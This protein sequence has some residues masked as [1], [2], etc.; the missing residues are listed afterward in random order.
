VPVFAAV[1]DAP[2]LPPDAGAPAWRECWSLDWHDPATGSA[3]AYRVRA[4]ADGAA[5]VRTWTLAGG[6]VIGRSWTS[7]LDGGPDPGTLRAGGLRLRTLEPLR[8]YA[9]TT[10]P[11]A[12][13][14]QAVDLTYTAAT[15]AFRFSMS[16]QRADPGGEHYESFGTVTGTIRGRTGSRPATAAE[17]VKVD[18]LGFY[19]HSWGV[20]NPGPQLVRSV[21]GMFE[22][23]L[24]F[25]VAEYSTPAG[26][27]PLGYVFE[28]GEFHGVEKAR[29]RAET[30]ES[31]L[32]RS[33]DVLLATADRRDFRIVT[34][35]APATGTGP[36]FAAF[37]LGKYRGSGLFER[38]SLG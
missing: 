33:C 18:G 17:A 28:G 3:A 29:F 9:V 15:D 8:S 16:G 22:A 24:F 30:D 23:G 35:L 32:P 34:A 12:G 11:G 19:R 37:A 26:R 38:H 21:H 5:E 10:D 2:H 31:G 20:P 25:S 13:P 36:Q 4:A 27:A 1:D 7:R 14:S 6:S